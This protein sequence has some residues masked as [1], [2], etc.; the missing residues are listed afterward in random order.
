MQATYDPLHMGEITEEIHRQLVHLALRLKEHEQVCLE[1]LGLSRMDAKTLY[2]LEPGETVPVRRLAERGGVDPSNLSAPI[3]R[4]E[5]RGLVER[6]PTVHDR[7]VRAVRLTR[8]G[9][10]MR[11]RLVRCLVDGHPAV[12]GLAP[13]EQER[14]RDLLRRL[15]L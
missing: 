14:L 10:R 12:A 4:L 13:D 8:A 9:V 11:E 15:D 5:S 3:E 1:R 6:Q 7:R 2:R